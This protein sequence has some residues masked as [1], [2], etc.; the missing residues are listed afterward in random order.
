MASTPTR[1]AHCWWIALGTAGLLLL[2]ACSDGSA[3]DEGGDQSADSDSEQSEDQDDSPGEDGESADEGTSD[4]DSSSE[5]SPSAK[6]EP[7][8][9]PGGGDE[10]FPDRRFVALYG[11]PSTPDLGPLGEQG[12]EETF[13]RLE[14]VVE[15][16]QEFSEEP[17]QPALEIIASV[18]STEPGA[19]G[20]YTNELDPEDLEP[21]VDAAEEADVYV[22]L[23]LQPG[24]AH[25]L[26]QAQEYEDLLARP[27]VGLALDPE[28]RLDPGQE[29]G[30]QVGSVDAEEINETS[31]WL[32]DL[33]AE[34]ELPQ[35]MF[36]IHQFT[37][38]MIQNRSD[39]D[40]EAEELAFVLHADGHGEPESKMATWDMLLDG[41]PDGMWMAWKNFRNEDFPTFT[42]EQTYDVEPQPWFVSFQ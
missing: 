29:H 23:D 28:W 33:T 11:T 16:Y 32:A 27:H 26:E 22:V 41:L 17:V 9:L 19:D 3:A 10:L 6:P 12:I 34:H 37:Q 18:A 39:I 21:W 13:E 20:N 14:P 4:G 35:K 8:E 40:T 42:A 1:P 36:L 15:E 25:F 2:N 30:A 31:E 38:P 7:A 24:H 5:E